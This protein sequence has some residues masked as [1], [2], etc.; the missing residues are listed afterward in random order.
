MRQSTIEQRWKKYEY[1]N[2]LPISF[3]DRSGTAF[4]ARADNRIGNIYIELKEKELNAKTTIRSSRNALKTQYNWR[5]KHYP[6]ENFS[7]NEISSALW[8]AGK[9][10]DCLKHCWNH[11][12]YKHKIVS[13]KLK[14]EGFD[15][16]IV[17]SKHSPLI[18]YKNKLI[19]FKDYYKK[20]H[21]LTVMLESEY[22]SRIDTI[23]DNL[24]VIH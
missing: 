18:K 14:A 15:Y 2:L 10:N 3:E 17:F 12:L 22:K 20:Y 5:F 11:S 1:Q 13:E 9:Y 21:D 6:P 8:N 19:P 24:K 23:E 4:K 7:H 16:W